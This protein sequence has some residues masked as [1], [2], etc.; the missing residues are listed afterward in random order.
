MV[1]HTFIL[2]SVDNAQ[3]VQEEIYRVLKP[4]GICV[5]M[6]HSVHTTNHFVWLL[7]RLIGPAWYL[8]FDCLFLDMEAILKTS[9][10][11]KID[12]KT[13]SCKNVLLALINPIK[14]GFGLKNK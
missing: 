7:Q 2:C 11:D 5:F 12:I 3:K 9:K 13:A 1:V 6:E 14:Y 4:G 8:C 10:Y